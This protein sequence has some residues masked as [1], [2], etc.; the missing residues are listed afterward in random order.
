[1]VTR[2]AALNATIPLELTQNASWHQT[3]ICAEVS[4][5]HELELMQSTLSARNRRVI[6]LRATTCDEKAKIERKQE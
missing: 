4:G 1:M 5:E 3:T 6:E 2:L